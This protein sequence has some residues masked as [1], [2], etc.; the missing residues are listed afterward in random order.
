MSLLIEITNIDNRTK[1]REGKGGEIHERDREAEEKRSAKQ[2]KER[3]ARKE[4]RRGRD[5]KPGG[6]KGEGK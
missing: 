5:M 4:N 3:K 2:S 1:L 6:G